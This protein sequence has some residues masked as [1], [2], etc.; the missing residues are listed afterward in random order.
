MR[1]ENDDLAGAGY[2]PDEVKRRLN[3]GEVAILDVRDAHEWAAGHIAGATWIP[4]A[5]LEE[6]LD[7]LDADQEWVC[8]CPVGRIS[9]LAADMLQDAGLRATNMRGGLLA[10]SRL[11][12]P[13]EK[14]RGT[15]R[16]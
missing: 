4:F 12:L 7:E 10:W 1:Q 9:D 13:L 11:R 15:S 2:G 16:S 14:G 6:R 5:E 8:V 3:A